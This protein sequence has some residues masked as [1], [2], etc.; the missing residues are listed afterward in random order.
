MQKPAAC[1]HCG[2][3]RMTRHEC[4]SPSQ[5]SK[6]SENERRTKCLRRAIAYKGLEIVGSPS[7]R[8]SI[9]VQMHE[10]R[11]GVVNCKKSRTDLL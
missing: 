10:S 1:I 9:L 11:L 7:T 8:L 4:L 2:D 3:A 5:C 6:V